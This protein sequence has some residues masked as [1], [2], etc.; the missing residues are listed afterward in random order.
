MKCSKCGKEINEQA[1]F[2]KYCGTP[3]QV[4]KQ[5]SPAN[6]QKGVVI[7]PGLRPTLVAVQPSQIALQLI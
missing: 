3:V 6:T 2:C 7:I 1:K 5:V 4:E